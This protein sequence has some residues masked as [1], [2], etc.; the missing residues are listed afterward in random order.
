M[1]KI[2][3]LTTRHSVQSRSF[4]GLLCNRGSQPIKP[5]RPNSARCATTRGSRA[6]LNSKVPVR[7]ER[8]KKQ[9]SLENKG[10]ILDFLPMQGAPERQEAARLRERSD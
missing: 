1:S 5:P 8:N 2:K 6:E 4:F 7:D 9:E 3:D 10:L